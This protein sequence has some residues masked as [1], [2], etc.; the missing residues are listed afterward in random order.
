[1][2]DG[3]RMDGH[4]AVILGEVLAQSM[5]RF[6]GT[7]LFESVELHSGQ[8][9]KMVGHSAMMLGIRFSMVTVEMSLGRAFQVSRVTP[10]EDRVLQVGRWLSCDTGDRD[11]D[12]LM[13]SLLLMRS[14]L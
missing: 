12:W 6:H 1:M 4:L 10:C 7:E 5:L 9:L 8:G 3:L 2:D 13:L 14:G 11:S